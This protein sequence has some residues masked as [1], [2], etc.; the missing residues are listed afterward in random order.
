M[1]LNTKDS[2]FGA[3]PL[4]GVLV[5]VPI[6]CPNNL[7]LALNPG[8]DVPP[9]SSNGQGKPSV[10]PGGVGPRGHAAVNGTR[11]KINRG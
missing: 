4:S 10:V 1:P 8:G 2:R 6:V 9:N 3:K 7:G 5:G 11:A